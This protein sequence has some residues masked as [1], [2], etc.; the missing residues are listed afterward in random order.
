MTAELTMVYIK[1]IRKKDEVNGFYALALHGVVRGL[2]HDIYEINKELLKILDEAKIMYRIV[3]GSEL[4][5][6]EKVRN[7]LTVGV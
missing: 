4:R 7:P 3:T 6:N 2:P 1:F 5:K